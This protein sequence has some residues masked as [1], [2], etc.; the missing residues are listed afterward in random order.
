MCSAHSFSCCRMKGGLVSPVRE[1]D[2]HQT[3][4]AAD[5]GAGAQG[6]GA[7]S[8]A[9]AALTGL[10]ARGPAPASS[11]WR[12]MPRRL[13]RGVSSNASSTSTL[14][15]VSISGRAP[16]APIHMDALIL[17]ATRR[18]AG[19]RKEQSQRAPARNDPSRRQSRKCR[20]TRRTLLSAHSAQRV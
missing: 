13:A 20:P 5:S 19:R 12:P 4:P 7:E 3:G 10:A 16:G 11:K 14:V 15:N 6:P 9:G 17:R 2:Q 1:E 8:G 18:D